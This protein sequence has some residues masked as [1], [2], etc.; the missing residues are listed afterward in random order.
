MTPEQRLD[1]LE[2]IAKLF[3]KAGL[4]ARREGR[5]QDK[6]L[7]HLISLQI[8]NEEKFAQHEAK[9]AQHQE[10]F[11][12]Q[13]EKIDILIDLQIQ[14]EERFGKLAESQANTDRRLDSLI[15]IIRQ[16]RNGNSST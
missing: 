12:N 9:F 3:V 5:E 4:R 10:K 1:R 2:R 14:N 8:H 15:D 13:T 6:K 11:A 7:D 16:G